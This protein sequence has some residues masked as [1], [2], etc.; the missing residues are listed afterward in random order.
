MNGTLRFYWLY[1][2]INLYLFPFFG[3]L[4]SSMFDLR[5]YVWFENNISISPFIW[6]FDNIFF[7]DNCR[8]LCRLLWFCEDIA[9]GCIWVDSF[10]TVPSFLVQLYVKSLSPYWRS[11]HVEKNPHGSNNLWTCHDLYLF[12]L[13]CLF[14]RYNSSS[15][16]NV[17]FFSL[18]NTPVLPFW[19]LIWYWDWLNLS[20]PL[21]QCCYAVWLMSPK[22]GA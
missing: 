1:N 6:G 19:R 5:F 12:L 4:I 22:F 9:H 13:E 16:F 20:W 2:S 3:I 18:K 7:S 15:L 8:V 14:K 10:R 11:Q 21:P 17:E